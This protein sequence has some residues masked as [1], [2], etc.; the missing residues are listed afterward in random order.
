[1]GQDILNQNEAGLLSDGVETLAL[2]FNGA[3]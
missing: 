3:V 1:M 2:S